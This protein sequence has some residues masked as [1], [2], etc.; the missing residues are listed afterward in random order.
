MTVPSDIGRIPY[1]ICTGFSSFTAEQ[2]KN[3]TVYFSLIVIRDLLDSDTLECW[4]HFVLAC[5]VFCKKQVTMEKVMLGD[6]HLLQF[7]KRTE[8]LFGKDTITPNMHFHCHLR[9][10]IMDYG[11]LHGFW[12]YA[13][14]RYNGILGAMPNNNHSIEVQIMQRFLRNAQTLTTSFPEEFFDEFRPLFPIHMQVSGSL[15]ESVAFNLDLPL[16]TLLSQHECRVT[17]TL[18]KTSV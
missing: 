11:P 9:E 12:L 18:F 10:C 8:R 15:A 16:E 4:R 2:W 14:E 3:W 1:K 7:C 6:A 17:K 13:F 5:R